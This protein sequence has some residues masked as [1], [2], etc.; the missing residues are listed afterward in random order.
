[1]ALQL[2]MMTATGFSAPE[3]YGRIVEINYSYNRKR[4]VAKMHWFKDKAAA[5]SSAR[6]SQD[7][8]TFEAVIDGDNLV[9]QAYVAFK[10]LDHLS[11]ASDV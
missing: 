10:G 8:V 5:D 6:L 9:A 7:T 11:G 3:A 1:M 4:T 2:S